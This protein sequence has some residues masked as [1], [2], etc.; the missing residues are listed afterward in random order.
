MKFLTIDN[1]SQYGIDQIIKVYSR[2]SGAD[3]SIKSRF[4]LE[5]QQ[6]HIIDNEI[7]FSES[8]PLKIETLNNLANFLHGRDQ[9]ALKG[10]VPKRL[11]YQDPTIGNKTFIWYREAQKTFLRFADNKRL[12]NDSYIHLPTLVFKASNRNLSVWAVK[13]KT[14]S[15]SSQLYHAPLLNVSNGRICLGTT[16]RIIDSE[17]DNIHDINKLIQYWEDMLFGSEF[18][19]GDGDCKNAVSHKKGLIHYLKQL[20]KTEERFN[21]DLLVPS[22]AKQIKNLINL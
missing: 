3:D 5:S 19:T 13:S 15:P 21:K 9:S 8:K 1:N 16:R 12:P 4:Y 7:I 20:S 2:E 11:I 18:N 17:I 10:F 14:A 6:A 22:Q